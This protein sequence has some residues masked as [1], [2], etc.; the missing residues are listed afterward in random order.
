MNADIIDLFLKRYS[1][2]FPKGYVDINDKQ[3]LVILES[4]FKKLDLDINIKKILKEQKEN[5]EEVEKEIEDAS[6]KEDLIKIIQELDLTSEQISRL[7]K[8]IANINVTDSLSNALSKI[9]SEK[10]ISKSEV[11][12]FENLI[13]D[14]GFVSSLIVHIFIQF[15]QSTE[16][17][18]QAIC[19]QDTG[20]IIEVISIFF[21]FNQE[22][23]IIYHCVISQ[24]V[25]LGFIIL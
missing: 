19:V 4:I 23:L 17:A 11:D 25:Q 10:N 7:K 1:Y 14:K 8:L 13:K 22:S 16:Y 20:A 24:A 21:I 12:K 18:N 15:V 6:S 5:E 9:S 3:D 2:K